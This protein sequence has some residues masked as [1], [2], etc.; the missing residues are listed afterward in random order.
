MELRASLPGPSWS[1]KGPLYT[2]Q[3]FIPES[4]KGHIGKQAAKWGM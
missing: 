2:I 1:S 4:L 3:S